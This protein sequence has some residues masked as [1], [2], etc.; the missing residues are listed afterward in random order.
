M[1]WF[2]LMQDSNTWT[3]EQ[4]EV[5]RAEFTLYKSK[6]R[7]LIREAD[8]YHV[9]GRPDGVHWDGI[10]YFDPATRKG[11]LFA[12][13]G[14]SREEDRHAYPVRGLRVDQTYRVVFQDHS[15]KDYLASGK[16]LLG[17]GI[18]VILPIP[19]SSELV[20]FEEAKK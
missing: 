8:L 15:S 7:P 14:S 16:E 2:S 13:H 5:A 12:F 4:H 18:K 19:N 10:E 1:G 11:V 9:S 6:L 3:A 20:F 17:L